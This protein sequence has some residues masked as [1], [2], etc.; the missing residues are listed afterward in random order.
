MIKGKLIFTLRLPRL[1]SGSSVLQLWLRSNGIVE[2][3]L[4]KQYN[5]DLASLHNFV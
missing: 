5:D 1:K 4:Q 2:G 3:K